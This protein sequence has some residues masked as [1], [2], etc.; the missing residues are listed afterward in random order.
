MPP[1]ENANHTNS[2]FFVH[3]ILN[4]LDMGFLLVV[5]FILSR[6]LHLA[7]S[8]K[9]GLLCMPHLGVGTPS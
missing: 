4:S 6:L 3:F 7:F 5:Y 8:D 1:M 2:E 9:L